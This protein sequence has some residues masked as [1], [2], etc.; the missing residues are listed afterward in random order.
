M[1]LDTDQA[2]SQLA[3][4]HIIVC[5]KSTIAVRYWSAVMAVWSV[6]TGFMRPVW[7]A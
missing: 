5:D 4:R 2:R 3:E 1:L 7:V 6:V